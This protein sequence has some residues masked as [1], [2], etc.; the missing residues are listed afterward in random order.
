MKFYFMKSDILHIYLALL[1]FFLANINLVSAQEKIIKEGDSWLYFDESSPSENW[2]TNNGTTQNWKTGISPLGYGDE[3]IKTNIGFGKDSTKKH[4]T[5][6]FKK[7][8]RIENPFEYLI[9][10]LNVQRDDGVVIYLNGYEIWRDNMPQGI[11]SDSTTASHLVF[12]DENEK[13]FITKILSP[14]DFLHG[15][16]T[17]SASVHQARETSSD[18]LFNLELIGNNNTD[19]LPLLLKKRNTKNI[20][21]NSKIKDL[22]HKLEIEKKDLQLDFIEHSYTN[23]LNALIIV[24]LLLLISL[25]TT[26]ILR[27][28]S[29]E[30]EKKQFLNNVEL[31]ELLK[32]KDQ[33]MMNI[34]L[35]SINNQQY[36]NELRKDL[37]KSISED[38]KTTNNNITK[39]IS[40]LDYNLEQDD[41]W[42]NLKKHFNAVHS[43][44][45]EKLINKHASLSETEIRHCV[46]MKLHMQTKEIARILHI[47]PRSVQ[48]S[49]Y[50]I[51][52][53]MNLNENTDLK[54]YLQKL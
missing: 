8:F 35:N 49:R 38:L 47:D 6:Y 50:R 20:V 7:T 19:M 29:K 15:T 42:D 13:L 21:L 9:Y 45:I 1:I 36:L 12:S 28:I 33:E 31:K 54:E 53:K 10:E 30:K 11:I 32:N 25:I 52:K 48:A 41:D 51:K 24:S 34:S 22:N 39:I 3:F 14:E 4:I 17:I 26:F 27:R 16:N 37:E 23:I 5:Q 18:C 44:F 43:G 40:Q 46:F 2:M